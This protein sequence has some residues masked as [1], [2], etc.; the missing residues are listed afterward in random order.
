VGSIDSGTNRSFKFVPSS[1]LLVA[2]SASLAFLLFAFALS[3][4]R[5][6]LLGESAIYFM[7][8]VGRILQAIKKVLTLLGPADPEGACATGA[9][10]S[11]SGV[12][13]TSGSPD[14]Y[15]GKSGSPDRKEL[16]TRAAS[17]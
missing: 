9:C 3:L 10:A 16:P 17:A 14:Y 15:G 2:A 4:L 7:A 13:D 5:F 1:D 6:R 8:S 12:A 11:T